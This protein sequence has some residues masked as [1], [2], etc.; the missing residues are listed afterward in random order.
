[1]ERY[2]SVSLL[3]YMPEKTTV[4]RASHVIYSFFIIYLFGGTN[5]PSVL[6]IFA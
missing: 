4:V 6:S 3:N 2:G 5:Q 1:M